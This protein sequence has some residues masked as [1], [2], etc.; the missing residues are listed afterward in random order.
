MD[1]ATI[2]E[3]PMK[4]VSRDKVIYRMSRENKPVAHVAPGELVCVE[5]EDCYSGR[6]R[7]ERDVFTQEMWPT[8]N[9]ATGPLYIDGA[10][11]G[12]ILRV[13]IRRIKTRDFA[14]MCVEHGSGA[15]GRWIEG[16]E[17]TIYPIRSGKLKIRKK[18]S[19]PIAPMV[20]VIGTAPAGDGL[21][22]G[23]PGEHGG[24]MDCKEI[25]AGTS[26]YL[27][28]NVPGALL[29]LGDIHAVMGDGEVC[30]CGAETAGEVVLKT[31]L[32]RAPLP[33]P[34]V[35]T[36]DWILFIAAGKTLDDCQRLVLDKAHKYLTGC[37]KLGANEAAR[38]MSL[39]GQLRVCQVVNPLK[40]MKFILP[41]RRAPAAPMTRLVPRGISA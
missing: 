24:N 9:P 18:L 27:P 17:T 28:V 10:K 38:T 6:L 12:D 32:V 3:S 20:G 22:T 34:C 41:K 31:A 11:P 39:L 25:G 30:I 35:E 16:I 15:L 26:V 19:V 7:T 23:T 4:R 29:A 33:T 36:K 1:Y 14:V 21:L 2:K 8:V 13:D 37:L 5:T 40:T